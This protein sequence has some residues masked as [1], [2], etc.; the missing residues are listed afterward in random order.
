M[1]TLFFGNYL[2][3]AVRHFQKHKLFWSVQVFGLALG[4][5]AVV[6]ILEF[7]ITEVSYDKFHSKADRIYRVTSDRYQQGKLVHHGTTTYPAVGPALIKDYPEIEQTTRMMHG[8]ADMTVR[9]D[10]NVIAGGKYLFADEHFLSVFDFRLLAGSQSALQEPNAVVLTAHQAKKYFNITE[11]NF[12]TVVGRNFYLGLN[13]HPYVV[14]AVCEDIPSNSHLQFDALVSYSTLIS[15]IPM[16]NDSWSWSDM[17]HY[18]VLREGTSG[19]QLQNKLDEF[20]RTHLASTFAAGNSETF[21]LQPLQDIHL[22]SDYEY[23]IAKTTN[24]KAVWGMLVAAFLILALSWINYMNLTLTRGIDRLKEVG[25]RKAMGALRR[26]VIAQF[27]SESFLWVICSLTLAGAAVVTLQSWFNESI[28]EPLSLVTVISFLDKT[29]VFVIVITLFSALLAAGLYP[30]FVLSKY[31]PINIVRSTSKLNSNSVLRKVL[32]VFQFG[33]T[34]CL[35]I[36]TLAIGNQLN[37]MNSA[38]LGI[39]ISRTLVINPPSMTAWDTTFVT[40]TESFKEEL[41]T[42]GQVRSVTNSVRLPGQRLPRISNL[43]RQGQPE[44]TRYSASVMGIGPDFF[45]SYNVPIVVG[46][47]F[48]ATDYHMKWSDVDAII[49]NESTAKILGF[50]SASDAV[51]KQIFA[52]TRFRRIVGVVADFHQES[53]KKHKEP[54]VFNPLYGNGHYLSVKIDQGSEHEVVSLAANAFNKF[55][56]GNIFD[57]S[58]L[59]DSFNTNYSDDR[60]FSKVTSVFTFLA[61]VIS[62]LGLISLAA[63]AAT[64]RTKEVGIRKVLGASTVNVLSLLSMDF[65]K[66][67]FIASILSLPLSYLLLDL[68]LA[69]YAYHITLSWHLFVI[70][71]IIMIAVAW[72]TLS[73]QLSKAAGA[74][75][76]D[77]LKH[78]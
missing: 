42:F 3:L 12:S 13:K 54:M 60:R 73:L 63:H 15:M 22:Y 39:D 61:I 14:T 69:Q 23:D 7:V 5:T 55:F 35:L 11:E 32:I 36:G 10:E 41:S 43:R 68:W 46:R 34:S 8:F 62:A 65:M 40:R 59:E 72:I 1:R 9:V 49:I 57:Y 21:S 53:L 77:T 76:A 52:E 24:G 45:D 30:A 26:Q 64:L 38:D 4:I 20:A 28:G 2:Q 74:N 51:D 58:F 67:V 44:D 75:P 33:A 78:E 56:P 71:T 50:A 17:R 37:F 70:P 29:S 47:K 6:F 48:Q 19:N 16:A 31:Q 27:I 66:P 25:I 18:I